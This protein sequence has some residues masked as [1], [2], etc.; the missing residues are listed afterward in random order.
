MNFGIQHVL[1]HLGDH[2]HRLEGLVAHLLVLAAEAEV[3]FVVRA[4][5]AVSCFV[6]RRGGSVC[7]ARR[8]AAASG[9][10]LAGAEQL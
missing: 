6:L 7:A 3:H 8:A 2:A 1:L 10:Q 9:L 5:V 4:R